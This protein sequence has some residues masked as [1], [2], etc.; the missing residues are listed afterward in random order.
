MKRP[1][2]AYAGLET[3]I[4]KHGME[5]IAPSK[6]SMTGSL[7][8]SVYAVSAPDAPRLHVY[9]SYGSSYQMG[10]TYRVP[11]IRCTLMKFVYTIG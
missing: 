5:K 11:A 10:K 1:V 6:D 8:K 3:M 4:Q 2:V 7:G 9:Q